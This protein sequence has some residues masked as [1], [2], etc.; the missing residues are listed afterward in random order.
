MSKKAEDLIFGRETRV[1]VPKSGK[2][3][4]GTV[5]G[6]CVKTDDEK[7]LIPSKI[8]KIKLGGNR[9]R[10]IDEEGEVAIYPLDFFLILSL[11]PAA[12]NTLAGVLG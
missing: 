6:V 5:F 4:S 11:S 2:G 12:E 1:K 3:D 7:L 9:A 8:Y 10:V